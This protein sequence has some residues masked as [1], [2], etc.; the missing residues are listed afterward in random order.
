MNEVL[1][2]LQVLQNALLIFCYQ[3]CYIDIHLG[4]QVVLSWVNIDT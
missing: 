2:V 1:A 3:F 4:V